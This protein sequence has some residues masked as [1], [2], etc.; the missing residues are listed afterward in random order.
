MG[1]SELT[2]R[3]FIKYSAAAAAAASIGLTVPKWAMARDGDVDRWVKGVCRFCGTG[4]GVYVGV[5]GDKVVATKGNPDAKTN[6]GFLCV[7]GMM[8]YKIME[9]P[10]RLK[11]PLV[12]QADGNFKEAGWDEALDLV[13]GKFKDLRT[14]YG[15]DA[16][17]YYG[18]GQAMTEETYT[19]NKFWKGGLGSNMV[20]GN[21]RLCMASAVGGYMSTYGSDEPAGSYADIEA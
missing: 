12:R 18:S 3:D 14:K 8:A 2:R 6:F 5:K 1:C 16:V 13:A 21:P 15:K 10:D 11:K 4:C 7:K 19:F 20:E 9:H 17:A